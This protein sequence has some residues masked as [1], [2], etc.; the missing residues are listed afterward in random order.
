MSLDL[1]TVRRFSRQIA[2]PDI[3]SEGQERLL[4]AEVALAGADLALETAARYLAGAGVRRFRLI[5]DDATAVRAA[6]EGM[7]ASVRALPWP[8]DVEGWARGV[9]GS[10]LVVR[11]GFDDDG[12]LRAAVREGVPLLVLR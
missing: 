1:A 10:S 6:A 11:S 4:A 7:G 8:A 5:A 12:L 3:G 9:R 2:L